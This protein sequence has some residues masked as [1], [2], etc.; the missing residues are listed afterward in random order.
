M[1]AALHEDCLFSTVPKQPMREKDQ[2][3][4]YFRIKT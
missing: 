2:I 4:M 3:S 1:Q